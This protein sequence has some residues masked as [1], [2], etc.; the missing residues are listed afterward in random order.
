MQQPVFTSIIYQ[1][2]PTLYPKEQTAK[3]CVAPGYILGTTHFWVYSCCGSMLF[4]LHDYV[5]SSVY[6]FDDW[7]IDF[8]YHLESK[9]V[10]LLPVC[11]RIEFF[12]QPGAQLLRNDI[13]ISHCQLYVSARQQAFLHFI[14]DDVIRVVSAGRN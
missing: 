13:V 2:D 7:F 5:I 1:Q 6:C 12:L 10:R 11:S 3:K 4:E 14:N 8:L 9:I